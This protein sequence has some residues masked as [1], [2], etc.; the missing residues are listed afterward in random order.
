MSPLPRV[1]ALR[2]LSP[3]NVFRLLSRALSVILAH[4]LFFPSVNPPDGEGESDR[5]E[6]RRC[7]VKRARIK[8]SGES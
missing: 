6:G 8:T 5:E 1:F 3:A 4:T 7:A 2:L